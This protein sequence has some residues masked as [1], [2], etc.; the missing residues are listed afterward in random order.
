[1]IQ[2][3]G[4][5]IFATIMKQVKV[6]LITGASSGIGFDA[7]KILAQQGHKVYAAARRVELMEPLK[8]DGVHVIR[9][10][11]TDEASMQQGVE[12]VIQ[13][14]G[15]IDVLVNN[16]GYG[17]FGAIETVPLEEARRQLEVNV[18]GPLKRTEYHVFGDAAEF[19]RN[20]P[21]L[22][23]AVSLGAAEDDRDSVI[24][25]ED[26][27]NSCPDLF[28][29]AARIVICEDREEENLRICQ[30]MRTWFP[31]NAKIHIRSSRN[32]DG[33]ER[34][35]AAEEIFTTELVMRRQLSRLGHAM[36]EIY[37][38]SAGGNAPEWNEL[39]AFLRQSNMAAADHL[40]VKIRILLGHEA[41]PCGEVTPELCGKA[42][43]RWKETREEGAELYRAIEHE[44]WERFHYLRNW[45]YAPVRDNR[46]RR[47]H[48][49]VAYQDLSPV[50]QAKDDYAWELLGQLS[51]TAQGGT[52][53]EE[54]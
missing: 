17:F 26:A 1:M 35:G 30:E 32:A 11:V 42:F 49:L 43:R 14:E 18:F 39:G 4:F 38:T 6:I 24:F 41:F 19:L 47:H 8:A 23:S 44:R 3:V 5:C 54:V 13:A 25:H 51:E 40:A 36:H 28:L 31:V 48:L 34:F 33:A 46:L 29:T 27:W 12:A 53:D 22:P 9:M 50:E 52:T 20:H 15:R 45:K 7:A 21:E 2:F 16:A 10:D 37:R